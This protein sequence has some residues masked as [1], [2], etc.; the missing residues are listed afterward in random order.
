MPLFLADVLTRISEWHITKQKK[1]KQKTLKSHLNK[2][3]LNKIRVCFP[4]VLKARLLAKIRLL[5]LLHKW[6]PACRVS[7]LRNSYSDC[8]Y[9]RAFYELN[10]THRLNYVFS[11][12]II[13]DMVDIFNDMWTLEWSI[14][15]CVCVCV[16]VCA[17]VCVHIYIYV[18]IYIWNR[19]TGEI[20]L[21]FCTMC[22]VWHWEYSNG[23]VRQNPFLV[24]G[25]KVNK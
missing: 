1:T 10:I 18:C 4:P 23:Y 2:S 6:L 15:L 24:I 17:C 20:L 19:E 11:L 8:W 21:L 13:Y 25:N 14:H 12:C 7:M 9:G 22:C 3:G 16:C 5:F